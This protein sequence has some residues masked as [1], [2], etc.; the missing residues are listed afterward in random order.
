MTDSRIKKDPALF[1][2]HFYVP[3]KGHCNRCKKSLIAYVHWRDDK[4]RLM[5][6]KRNC[7]NNCVSANL[8]LDQEHIYLTKEQYEYFKSRKFKNE[9]RFTTD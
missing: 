5:G 2:A 8:K 6:I 3:I 1:L 9:P 7:L 4:A